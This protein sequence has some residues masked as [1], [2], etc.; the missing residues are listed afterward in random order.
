MLKVIYVQF[1]QY[2]YSVVVRKGSWIKEERERTGRGMRE[3]DGGKRRD[4][5]RKGVREKSVLC[6][7]WRLQPR[8]R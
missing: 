3:E 5:G 4:R 7:A 1:K 6:E 8:Y 2:I